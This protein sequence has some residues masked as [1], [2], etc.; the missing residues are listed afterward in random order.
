M[1]E[2]SR[3]SRGRAAMALY[4]LGLA[5]LS[6]V[7]RELEIDMEAN[8]PALQDWEPTDRTWGFF[9]EHCGLY[10]AL[11]ID[12]RRRFNR[13]KLTVKCHGRQKSVT[14]T[15]GE[16][17][18]MNDQE[19]SEWVRGQL[20]FLR[21]IAP[22]E[23]P[24]IPNFLEFS[25]EYMNL[26]DQLI[27]MR[28]AHESS[29]PQGQNLD[30]LRDYNNRQYLS[31][32]NQRHTRT[33]WE[34]IPL[35]LRNPITVESIQRAFP[36]AAPPQVTMPENTLLFCGLPMDLEDITKYLGRCRDLVNGRT[37]QIF[38]LANTDFLALSTLFHRQRGG[39]TAGFQMD[40]T[41]EIR[42]RGI[43]I[44]SAN[45]RRM[46]LFS[47]SLDI[48]NRPFV[49][50]GNTPEEIFAPWDHRPQESP[51]A[52]PQGT[53]VEQSLNDRMIYL[54]PEEEDKE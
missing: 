33:E 20:T 10:A 28:A 11:Y 37:V 12:E 49:Y 1:A 50:F 21:R 2:Q 13:R 54:P 25:E 27:R 8:K 34:P 46:E 23:R 14:I 43:A 24:I 16:Y 17:G 40:R 9:C 38:Y 35:E 30:A 18:R 44:R 6:F 26:R 5:P 53:P 36:P 52:V 39:S 51:Q 48:S 41:G 31:R 22:P 29:P 15:N 32:L 47:C 3:L 19:L 45:A 42:F 7:A 4:N